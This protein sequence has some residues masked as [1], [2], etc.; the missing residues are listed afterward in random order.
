MEY[1]GENREKYHSKKYF[2]CIWLNDKYSC[3]QL[4]F[5]I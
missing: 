3:T 1:K 5:N 2:K 4:S